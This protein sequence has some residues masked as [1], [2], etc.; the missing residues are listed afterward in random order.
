MNE[1][2]SWTVV[3]AT[4]GVRCKRGSSPPGESPTNLISHKR[5][6]KHSHTYSRVSH[7]FTPIY[8]TR[9]NT[10]IPDRIHTRMVARKRRQGQDRRLRNYLRSQNGTDDPRALA[11]R[12]DQLREALRRV[13]TDIAQ[14]TEREKDGIRR[15]DTESEEE[16]VTDGDGTSTTS[17]TSSTNTANHNLIADARRD[18]RTRLEDMRSE[19]GEMLVVNERLY[20]RL[21]VPHHSRPR[22]DTYTS[23]Q[24]LTAPPSIPLPTNASASPE[25]SHS[26][27]PSELP[28]A[29]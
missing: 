12:C 29:E 3:E 13:D 4:R 26:E 27:Q 5:K 16:A 17:T 19:L 2:G 20:H 22:T 8:T 7:L 9:C 10:F 15:V 14:L 28:S 6:I 25:T 11:Q 23:P 21:V 1:K 18:Q 24:P